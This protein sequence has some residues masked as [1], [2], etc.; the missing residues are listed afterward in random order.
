MLFC[1][2]LCYF[3]VYRPI[4]KEQE[5]EEKRQK[6][7]EKSIDELGQTLAHLRNDHYTN[8]RVTNICG[9]P[10]KLFLC[11]H[12]A[13]SE[14]AEHFDNYDSMAEEFLYFFEGYLKRMVS[15]NAAG[16]EEEYLQ[17]NWTLKRQ[18]L[19]E[20]RNKGEKQDIFVESLDYQLNFNGGK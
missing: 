2:I 14:A 17:G 15:N 13:G 7:E 10:I 11:L 9:V 16:H 6:L 12:I 4:L 18:A 8:T 3:L 5:E 1:W 19:K 20:L